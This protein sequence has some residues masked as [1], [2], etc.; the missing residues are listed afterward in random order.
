M[1]DKILLGIVL[2]G[3]SF[4]RGQDCTLQCSATGEAMKI[5]LILQLRV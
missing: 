5:D 2:I 1:F 3:K 4:C